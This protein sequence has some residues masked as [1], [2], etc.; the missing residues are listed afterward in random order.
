M[1]Q[2]VHLRKYGVQT[3]VDF[4]LYEVDGVDLRTD[5]VPAAADCEV[6]KDEGTS[7]QCTNT[8]TD[9]GSTYSIV[10]TATE[11]QAAR[12]VLKVVDAAT[13]VFLDKVIHIETYGNASAMHAMDFDE[14]NGSQF[15]EAGGTGDQL[16]AINLPNQTMD[17]VG[18]I[19]GNLSGSVGSVT[20]AV[21]SVVGDTKQTADHTAAIAN[22]PTVAEFNA[23]TIAAAS[24][25]DPAADTVANVTTVGTTTTNTDMRGTDSAAL[26][27]VATELRLAELD[28][29]N[30]PADVAAIP[31]TAMRGTDSAALASVATEARL[32]ELDAANLP[33][34]I[35]AIPT[36]A[37][38]GTDGVDTSTMRGTDSAA[39]ATALATAQLDLDK[40]TGTDGATLATAQALY[41]PAIP[42][43]VLT[44]VNAA[45]DTAIA[46]LA[47][48]AP[49]AT[50]TIRT[51][52][53]LLYMMGRNNATV[54][55]TE[56]GVY[57]DAG[58][59]IAKSTLSDDGTTFTDGELV[60]GA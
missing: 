17:I 45:L 46:E 43:E 32:A 33:A 11:M 3:T 50:P 5:W 37:M 27:S 38:R 54:T 52:L 58:T 4:E 35:A 57:N 7:T 12:L 56:K 13:K 59:K 36:T 2:G 1:S 53:M 23:R 21:G 24:Y 31:T 41:A 47:Q 28:P 14:A 10:L 22:I 49:T 44:Q 34:D 30:L 42:S 16:T 26:A 60:S 6:M 15:T 51:A 48:A 39:L 55:A 8:A 25:F 40:I 29:A 9:E 19:T 18:S 20:G